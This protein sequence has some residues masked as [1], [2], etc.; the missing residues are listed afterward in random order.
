MFV[1]V[2]VCVEVF[3]GGILVIMILH[4]TCTHAF[5]VHTLL[6]LL[7]LFLCMYAA[8]KHG[9]WYQAYVVFSAIFTA[10]HIHT[11]IV[12]WSFPFLTASF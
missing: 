3:R 7:L 1:R 10:Q 4:D 6:L 9:T 5:I 8:L 11:S 2:C 12:Q